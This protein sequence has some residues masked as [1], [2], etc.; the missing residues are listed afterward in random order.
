MCGIAG[1]IG[2]FSGDS[3]ENSAIN[4]LLEGISILQNRGYDSAGCASIC[5]K[6]SSI[7]T[8]KY[9]TNGSQS[10]LELLIAAAPAIHVNNKV[11]IAHTRWATHGKSSDHNAHPHNDHN[12]LIS[13]VHNGTIEN[14]GE[15]REEL[16]AAGVEFKSETDSEVIAQSI[17]HYLTA[18]KD[19]SQAVKMALAKLKGTYGLCILYKLKPNIITVAKQGM[20]LCIG[21]SGS[22]DSCSRLFI[23]SEISAFARYLDSYLDLADGQILELDHKGEGVDWSKAKAISKQQICL[24]PSPFKHWTIK[25]IYEQPVAAR[26][27]LGKGHRCNKLSRKVSLNGLN[28]KK[29]ELLAVRNLVLS[30]CGTSLFACN[31]AAGLF[32]SLRLFNT[33]QCLDA[34]EVCE[35]S[36]PPHDGGLLVLTQSGETKDTH[37]ALLAAQALS[38]PSFSVVNAVDSLI[39]R[40][41]GCGVYLNVGQEQAVASTKAFTGQVLAAALI[42]AW[43]YQNKQEEISERK[44]FLSNNFTDK[45]LDER[46]NELVNSILAFPKL[47]KQ[48]LS[49]HAQCAQLAALIK[50]SNH[51]F[52]LGKGHCEAVAKEGALKIKE[53][54]YVHAEGFNGGALKH[55]PF[56]LLQQ[57]I[58]VIFIILSDE[59]EKLMKI[60]CAEVTARGA[61]AIIITD[62]AEMCVGCCERQ[63]IIQI[64]QCGTLTALLA[65]IPLQLLA[66]ELAVQRGINPDRPRNLAK[67]VTVD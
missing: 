4:F 34:A 31:F 60:A 46:C 10:P 45:M 52:I 65:V 11:G 44:E 36:F 62:S 19:F 39:A 43:I 16:V 1:F 15:L 18:G 35:E 8:T 24:S 56:A 37:R 7:I 54:S 53:I 3:M 25:E 57:G 63:N 51:M 21:L 26:A 49:L 38:V 64:P 5:S 58:P 9:G 23:A 59:H 48:A 6:D 50:G 29:L 32:R 27:V 22:A 40:T 28:A 13:L 67:A 42:S 41:T 47:S 30:A 20:P 55:G 61:T 66:Y 17:G 12:N 33:V 2:S 14:A